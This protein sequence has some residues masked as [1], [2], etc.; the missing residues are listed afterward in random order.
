MEEGN[1]V[2]DLHAHPMLKAYLFNYK[3]WKRHRPPKGFFPLCMRTDLDALIDGDVRCLL[4]ATYII[5]SGFRDLFPPLR[6]LLPFYPRLRRMMNAEPDAM[7][8]EM[9]DFFEAHIEETRRRRGDVVAIARNYAEM[10]DI[11]ASGRLCLVHA[12]EGGHSLN[13]KLENVDKLAERGVAYLTIAHLYPNEAAHCVD[14]FPELKPLRAIGCLRYDFDLNLGITDFG[15]QA[16]ERMFEVGIIADMTHCT[17]I[18]R[19]QI[20]DIR[21]ASGTDRPLVMTHVGV[22][23][24]APYP[25]SPTKEDIREIADTGGVAG[26]IFM[27]HW[28]DK[29]PAKYAEAT[30]LKTV[31]HLIQHGGEDVVAFGSDFDGFTGVPKDFASPRDFKRLRT[32]LEGK[33]TPEQVEKFLHGNADRVLQNG[34]GKPA[35]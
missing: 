14:G 16:L 31:D 10:K 27:D 33:Y 22:H 32:L 2:I 7:T 13:G 9:F 3:F 20:Y 18:G 28:I 11:M 21:R 4:M 6:L 8:F 19:K 35:A 30:I 17:P 26:F 1:G 12:A 29:P 24:F 5:E 15:K 25:M 34:W 23:E